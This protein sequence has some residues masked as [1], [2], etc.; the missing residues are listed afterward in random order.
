MVMNKVAY[1]DIGDVI[2]DVVKLIGDIIDIM[3]QLIKEENKYGSDYCDG[4]EGC[5]YGGG[6]GHYRQY[7]E[8]LGGVFSSSN[9]FTSNGQIF[10]LANDKHLSQQ[11]FRQFD[12]L[13]KSPSKN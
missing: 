10:K 6:F 2:G 3:D 8:Q 4:C 11:K 1:T 12:Q 13:Q 9:R 5:Y 7:L